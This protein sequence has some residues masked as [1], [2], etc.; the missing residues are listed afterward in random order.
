MLSLTPVWWL[1]ADVIALIAL[2]LLLLATPLLSQRLHTR[3]QFALWLDQN[4]QG[5]WSSV[6]VQDP[7]GRITASVTGDV[8][9]GRGW[10]HVRGLAFTGS[11]STWNA[12]RVPQTVF[13]HAQIISL[14]RGELANQPSQPRP[15]SL[16]P[17]ILLDAIAAGRSSVTVGAPMRALAVA[18]SWAPLILLPL[19]IL[20]GAARALRR[21]TLRLRIDAAEEGRCPACNYTVEGIDRGAPCPECGRS[22][23]EIRRSALLELGDL[24]PTP[25]PVPQ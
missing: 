22:P 17:S 7:V 10:T 13:T 14:W 5:V 23:R 12:Q 4:S 18:A 20:A 19:A 25:P 9:I 21:R 1:R 16:S 2:V 24:A 8:E 3:V 15:D 6:N 11:G